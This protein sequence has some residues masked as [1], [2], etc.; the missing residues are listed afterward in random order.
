MINYK[1]ILII[2]GTQMLGRDFVEYLLLQNSKSDIYLANRGITNPDL[3]KDKIKHIYIDRY[4]GE[5]ENLHDSSFDLVVD[6]SCYNLGDFKKIHPNINCKKYILI[7]TTCADGTDKQSKENFENNNIFEYCK[8]K[9]ELENYAINFDNVCVVRPPIVYGSND[10]T[11]RFYEKDGTIYWT[12]DN[13]KV[14]ANTNLISVRKLTVLLY[15]YIQKDSYEKIISVNREGLS[16]VKYRYEYKIHHYESKL[17]TIQ[18]FNEPFNHI[19][20]D[21]LFNDNIY[22]SLCNKFS[23]FISKTVPYKNQK[24]ATSN[25]D[26]YIYGLSTKELVDGYDFFASEELKNFVEK[27]FN[28]VTTKHVAPSVHFHKSPSKSGFIHRDM[29][30]VSFINSNNK[31]VCTGGTN[32]TDDTETNPDTIKVMRTIAMIY[33]FNNDNSS[34]DGGGT[35][36]YSSYN[37]G[38]IKTIEPINNRLFIFEITHNSYH[39]F[40]GCD[41]DRSCLVNWFHSGPAYSVNRQWKYFRKNPNL[42]ERWPLPDDKIKYWSIENDPE[43]NKYFNFS[44]KDHFGVFI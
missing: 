29:N 24:N 12:H 15:N 32:Y 23:I 36:I 26:A 14:L 18:K 27:T 11:G 5:C 41:Y 10:Y 34:Y 44:I 38:L 9:E 35:G 8:N 42:I 21:N 13:S 7:S 3:F 17:L 19:I 6:F 20:I 4:N 25:Y 2:G 30:I 37:G 31:F 28:I 33:Y 1:K 40:I 16:V 39:A 22:A 43:Y